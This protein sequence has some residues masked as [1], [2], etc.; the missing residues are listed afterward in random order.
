MKAGNR[1][2]DEQAREIIAS[3]LLFDISD[4][5][6]ELVTITGCSVS[7][8]RAYCDVYY[9]VEPQRYTEVEAAFISSKGRIRSLMATKLAWKKA[10]ELRFHLDETI[11]AAE[12][13]EHYITMEKARQTISENTLEEDEE[14]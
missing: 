4:P 8:D 1:K 14:Y 13:L 12:K 6:L 2:V 7:Y 10:P 3:I 9:T 5:R 11:D